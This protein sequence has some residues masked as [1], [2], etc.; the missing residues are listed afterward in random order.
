MQFTAHR[1]PEA[2][3]GRWLTMDA[4]D[5]DGD[6]DIDLALGAYNI[7]Q[8]QIPAATQQAWAQN[9]TPILILK[10]KAK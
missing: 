8:G 6:G 2:D 7:P 9:P 10:N 4:G 1:L 3:R 5:M